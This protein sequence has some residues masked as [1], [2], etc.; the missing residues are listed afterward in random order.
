MTEIV[1]VKYGLPDYEKE[2]VEQV[3]NTVSIPY[4]LTIYDNY[5]LDE[6]LSVVWNRLIRQSNAEFVCLLNNDTVPQKDWL[7]KML[8][9][10]K[11]KRVGAVGAISNKAGGMQG[12]WD[13]S[14]EETVVE[15]TTLSGFCML[16]RKKAF[17][18][19]G[20]F[21]ERFELYG[22]DSEFS[23]R[24]KK[25]KWKLMVHMGAYVY[26]HKQKSTPVAEAR[27]KDIKAIQKRSSAL[28][29]QLKRK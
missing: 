12:G 22:E 10:M 20:G 4:H 17:D 6:N 18:E 1:I 7:S 14:P 2:T 5:P 15:T 28:F 8:E 19:V 25:F 23:H 9:V 29:D 26:H 21:D 3:L 13:K 27:G 11:D 24:L 16:I